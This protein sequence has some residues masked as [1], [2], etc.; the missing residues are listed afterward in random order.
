MSVWKSVISPWDRPDRINHFKG[1][2]VV[3]ENWSESGKW[4][5]GELWRGGRRGRKEVGISGKRARK[6]EKKTSLEVG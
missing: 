4:G 2:N 6:K 3:G 5:R 1:E